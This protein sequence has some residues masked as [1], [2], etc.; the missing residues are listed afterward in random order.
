VRGYDLADEL[1]YEGLEVRRVFLVKRDQPVYSGTRSV[2]LLFDEQDYDVGELS[3]APV[4]AA[5]GVLRPVQRYV[6]RP[7]LDRAK[8]ITEGVLD[9]MTDKWGFVR[10]R[11]GGAPEPVSVTPPILEQLHPEDW[12]DDR[13]EREYIVC[14]GNHRVVQRVWLEERSMPAV[15]IV[16]TPRE[17]YYARPF[18]RFE[19]DYTATNVQEIAPDTISKYSP[20][21][22]DLGKLDK[23]S[24]ATLAKTER[25][26]HYRRYFRDL[27]TGFGYM[28]GQGGQYV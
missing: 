3:H 20:R 7:G 4:E 10:I 2:I 11:K 25:R 9:G 17:P 22:V 28:G 21:R 8:E 23:A 26:Y 24:Q 19:W 5:L 6:L 16:G 15:A 1:A 13:G 12:E 27:T 14:D 18:S